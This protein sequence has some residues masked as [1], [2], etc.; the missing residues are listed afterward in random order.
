MISAEI[1]T[2]FVVIIYLLFFSVLDEKFS[3]G[4]FNFQIYYYTFKWWHLHWNFFLIY[5]LF[6]VNNGT[7]LVSSIFVVVVSL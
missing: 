4:L 3:R 2:H 5:L 7:Y 1:V 6:G